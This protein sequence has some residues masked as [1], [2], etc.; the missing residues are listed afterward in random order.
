MGCIY[1]ETP[2]RMASPIGLKKSQL[3]LSDKS[4]FHMIDNLSGAFHAFSRCI[5]TSISAD[6]ILL[7]R[8]LRWFTNLGDLPVRMMMAPFCLKHAYCFI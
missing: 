3:I 7:Q 4:D 1:F 6:E 8:F 2:C 5:L